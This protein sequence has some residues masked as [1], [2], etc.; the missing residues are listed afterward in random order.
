MTKR[1]TNGI[2]V[3]VNKNKLRNVDPSINKQL[4]QNWIITLN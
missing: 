4:N 1:S 2:F 3:K